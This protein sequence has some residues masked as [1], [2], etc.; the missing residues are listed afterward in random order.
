MRE[1]FGFTLVEILVT[2]VIIGVLM[3]I[4]FPA[5]NATREAARRAQCLSNMRQIGLAVH[6]F[7]D[8]R[9]QLPY[10]A[11]W[12]QFMGHSAFLAVLPYVEEDTLRSDYNIRQYYTG[13]DNLQVI[14]TR[15]PM[16][17]CPS[18]KLPRDVPE[19]EP[20]CGEKGAP[21]SYAVCIG[22]NDAWSGPHNGAI[23]RD[24]DGTLSLRDIRDGTSRTLM[25]GELDYGLRNYT[26][27]ICSKAGQPRGGLARWGVGY[28]G[29]SIA[30]TK[31]LFNAQE[32]INGFDEYQTFRSDHPGGVNFVMVDGSARFID[33]LID[34]AVL[35]ALATRKGNEVTSAS[36]WE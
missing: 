13:P 4:L 33:E 32:M 24:S 17:L 27:S 26:W 25:I 10:A 18:M 35:D 22:S 16:F 3:A 5:I 8:A 2:L 6:N 15:I 9:D 29:V 31:G 23:V 1:K 36:D 21:G 12:T 14:E 19:P 11:Y 30:S 28:P 34:A 20:A 7:H